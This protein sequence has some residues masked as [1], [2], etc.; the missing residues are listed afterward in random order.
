[1]PMLKWVFRLMSII[2]P[3]GTCKL[4]WSE[5]LWFVDMSSEDLSVFLVSSLSA[6]RL[7]LLPGSVLWFS[8]QA[9]CGC[10][11]A[12]P[13]SWCMDLLAS[14]SS[15]ATLGSPGCAQTMEW[16]IP[17]RTSSIHAVLERDIPREVLVSQHSDVSDSV[18]SLLSPGFNVIRKSPCC[19]SPL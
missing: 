4:H 1:M 19:P 8:S 5:V 11:V 14:L 3:C 12:H 15:S 16:L 9:V 17:G 10:M 6:L 2:R 13:R 7:L 18:M